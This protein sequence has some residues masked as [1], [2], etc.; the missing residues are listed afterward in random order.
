ME[1]LIRVDTS[2]DVENVDVDLNFQ[3]GAFDGV[4]AWFDDT[5]ASI[6][7]GDDEVMTTVMLSLSFIVAGVWIYRRL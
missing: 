4:R 5:I 6:R 7:A 3:G 1:V 2:V